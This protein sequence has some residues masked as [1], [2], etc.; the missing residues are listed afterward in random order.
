MS[1]KLTAQASV[2]FE[3][4]PRDEVETF[5]TANLAELRT[6]RAA[7]D[8]MLGER[9]GKGERADKVKALLASD[10]KIVDGQLRGKA[11]T[12]AKCDRDIALLEGALADYDAV[13][14]VT[15]AD[16]LFAVTARPWGNTRAQLRVT[17]VDPALL[18]LRRVRQLMKL[19]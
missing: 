7:V 4:P 2:D 13:A 10:P 16:S 9:I 8:K 6:H 1:L 5:V 18:R 15:N 14:A 11:T 17:I 19:A 12:V 3:M